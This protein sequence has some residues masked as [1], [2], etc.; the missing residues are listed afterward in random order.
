MVFSDMTNADGTTPGPTTP[1]IGVGLPTAGPDATPEAI[2]T[3]A[4]TA[5]RLGFASV[6]SFER[7][8]RPVSADGENAYGL[9]H[10]YA[11][12]LDPIEAL[13]WATAHTSRVQLGTSVLDTLFHPPVVL[14]KR[15]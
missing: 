6:W 10:H 13:V 4:Q 2:V 5:E 7:L 9:P 14:A 15:I 12:V 11:S 3:V 8:L 1:R